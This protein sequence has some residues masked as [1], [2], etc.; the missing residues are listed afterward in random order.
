LSLSVPL[1]GA[2]RSGLAAR[3][4]NGAESARQAYA[5]KLA[6]IEAE[7][8]AELA[9]AQGAYEAW[10]GAKAGAAAMQENARLAQRAY[11]LGETD[12]QSLLAARRQ[13]NSAA[14]AALAARA[15]AVHAYGGLLVDAHLVWGLEHD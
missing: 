11:R 9:R 1:P 8:G 3:A 12:L 5:L 13:A 7:I 15:Q 6:E 14:Q 2:R 10:Q 4:A